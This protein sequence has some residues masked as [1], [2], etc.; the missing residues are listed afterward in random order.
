V[1]RFDEQ[2]RAVE[3]GAFLGR[4]PDSTL[5]IGERAE[6]CTST[7]FSEP[8]RHYTETIYRT[9]LECGEVRPQFHEYT[10]EEIISFLESI[11][12]RSTVTAQTP[13]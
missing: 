12:V 11:N 4:I 1:K 6:F 2:G 9:C 10:Q 8:R 5:T 3:C 7:E 13:L